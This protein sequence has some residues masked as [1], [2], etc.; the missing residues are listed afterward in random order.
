MN[1]DLWK[2]LAAIIALFM[3]WARDE[4]E[5][6]QWSDVTC[7][8]R[9]LPGRVEALYAPALVEA[10]ADAACEPAAQTRE[11]PAWTSAFSWAVALIREP[12][13]H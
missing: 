10:G 13:A 9:V 5:E 3:L 11:A 6:G 1:R 4:R 7:Q 8:S 12:S 2:V